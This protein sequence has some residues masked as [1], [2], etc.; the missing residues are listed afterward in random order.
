MNRKGV[1]FMKYI[2][3]KRNKQENNYGEKY[4]SSS[5]P[6][7]KLLRKNLVRSVPEKLRHTKGNVKSFNA[8]L[9]GLRH[10]AFKITDITLFRI[11]IKQF[12]VKK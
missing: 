4:N 10:Y 8:L 5:I 12:M 7:K 9:L 2:K 1:S 11:P 6:Y 3:Q